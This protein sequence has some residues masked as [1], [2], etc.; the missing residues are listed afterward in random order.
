MDPVSQNGDKPRSLLELLLFSVASAGFLYFIYFQVSPWI[1]SQKGSVQLENIT[2][3][4]RG[5]LS[6]EAEQD[7]FELYALYILMFF[8]LLGVYVLSRIGQ[9][10]RL[11]PFFLLVLAA[12][13]IAFFNAVGFQPPMSNFSIYTLPSKLL[14]SLAPIVIVLPVVLG[15]YFLQM[16]SSRWTLIASTCLLI[17]LCFVA[18]SPLSLFDASYIFSPALRILHGA[19]FS[20][21]YFQYDLL[22]SLF[23]VLWMKL[24]FDLN[25]IAQ[26]TAA[27]SYYLLILG[28]FSFARRWFIDNRLSVFLLAALVLI[29]IYAGPV[30]ATAVLQVTPLRLD[31]WF[32]LLLLVY[33]KGTHH[34]SAGLFCG[35][36]LLVHK[37]FGIIYTAAYL[38]LLVT[39]CI[40]EA[41]ILVG[42][43][44]QRTLLAIGSFFKKNYLA[45]LL[46]MV[47]ALAHYMVFSA[48]KIQGDFEYIKL[49]IGFMKIARNSFY[50]YVVVII[51][52]TFILL[53]RM[54]TRVSTNYLAAGFCLIYLAIGNSLYFFGRSHENN[55]VNISIVLLLLFFLL[56]DITSHFLA[57]GTGEPKRLLDRRNFPIVIS[58]VFIISSV[59]WYGDNITKKMTIQVNNALD[60][61]ILPQHNHSKEQIVRFL[62]E[63]EAV[64][65]NN[66]KIYFVTNTPD[67]FLFYY[68]GGYAPVGYFNPFYTRI[69]MDELNNF[70]RTLIKNGHYLVIDPNVFGLEFFPVREYRHE[71]IQG[72]FLIWK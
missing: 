67:D 29:R 7:G 58:L 46:I 71:E 15:L 39:I 47:G 21:I 49:N 4:F 17:P 26:I 8:N 12:I 66:K 63:I 3:W 57:I 10:R 24:D 22:L 38:Q 28:I 33:F 64:S 52:L 6:N 70:L 44:A 59:V 32:V 61:V 55:I 36:M 41:P 48:G 11:A 25:F 30:D 1:W 18:T 45:L 31:M 20:D 50:W 5:Y 13:S 72:M 53:L 60:Q 54:R 65:G 23:A 14:Q 16:Y 40:L 43:T 19:D 2:P 42:S 9:I 37:N 27:G 56:L 51:G 34:W 69:F 35:L 62:A 68:Y